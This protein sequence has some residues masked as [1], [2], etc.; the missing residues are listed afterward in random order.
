MTDKKS[1]SVDVTTELSS[2]SLGST[3]FKPPDYGGGDGDGDGDEAPSP[4][5]RWAG[6][7]MRSFDGAYDALDPP[8]VPGGGGRRPRPGARAAARHWLRGA[9]DGFR[10]D[11]RISVS[12]KASFGADGRVFDAQRTALDTARAPLSRHLRGRHL[13]MIAFGGSIGALPRAFDA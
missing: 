8:G 9:L 3:D 7:T 2:M 6:R 4:L 5:P 10:R 13:Q 12:S 1:L 11:P